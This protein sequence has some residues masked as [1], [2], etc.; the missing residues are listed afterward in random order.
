MGDF[1]RI[2]PFRVTR[3]SKP[4]AAIRAGYQV[5][6]TRASTIWRRSGGGNRKSLNIEAIVFEIFEDRAVMNP[7]FAPLGGD[8]T[9][10]AQQSHGSEG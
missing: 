8:N 4:N 6:A 10:P 5:M 2:Q 1:K 7:Y 9:H 3:F